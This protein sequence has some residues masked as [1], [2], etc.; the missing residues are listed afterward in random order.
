MSEH[1]E[2]ELRALSDRYARAVDRRDRQ[3]LVDVFA[4]DGRLHVHRPGREGPAS[5]L[6]GRG[7]IAGVVDRVSRFSATYH[8]VANATYELGEEVATGEVYC[9]AHHLARGPDGGTDLVMYIRYEDSY[10]RAGGRWRIAER[11][12]LVEW[13][14]TRPAD[15]LPPP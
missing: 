4:P 7:E 1:G 11:H 9:V 2:G 6:A 3:A 13:T 10:A 12:V 5:T 14:E 8:L 15:P